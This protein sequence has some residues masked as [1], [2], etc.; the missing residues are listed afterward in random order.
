MNKRLPGFLFIASGLCFLLTAAFFADR[1]G[2]FIAIGSAQVAVGAA[3]LGRAKARAK[4]AAKGADQ[5]R[6]P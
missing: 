6:N 1:P 5:Q 2:A 3:L 4:A